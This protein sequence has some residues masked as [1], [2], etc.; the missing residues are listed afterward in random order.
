MQNIKTTKSLC[1]E[2]LRV[3]DAE[4]YEDNGK[5][6]I[7]KTCEIHGNFKDLYWS[8]YSLFEKA[9]KYEYIGDGIKNPRTSIDKGCPYDCGICPSHKS[10]T[11]LAIIDVTNRCNL[12]CPICF[13]NAAATGYVYEPTLEEIREMLKNLRS[14]QPIAPNSIQFSGGEPTVREDLP[15]LITMAKELGFHHVEVNTNGIRIAKDPEYLKK[16]LNAGLSTLY[17]Q[18]DGLTSEPY[19]AARGLDLLNI[20]LKVIE[21]ARKVGLDSIVL[22]PTIVKGINDNQ[23]GNI[24]R[25]AAKNSDVIRGVNFQPVSITGRINKEKLEE[26]RITIPDVIKLAE[27]QTNG[28]IKVSDFYPTPVVLPISKAVGA[29]KRRRYQEFTNHQHCGMATLIIPEGDRLVPITRYAN[30]EKFM[31][32]MK[33]V[34]DAASHGSSFKARMHLLSAIRHVKLSLIKDLILSV[35]I[36][37]DY[38]SLG[39]FMRKVILIGCMHFMDP[40]NFDLERVKRCTI[41]YAVPEGK[42]IPFCTMNSIHRPI[43]ERKYSK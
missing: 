11:V 9:N 13:A 28:E 25:F 6:Y 4:I 5:V 21:N 42:I 29:L 2:C 33:K 3:I 8:D 30:I 1:P 20:K 14:N 18:F 26:M 38:D 41:H 34:Y 7:R 27:E 16:L 24:I 19:L 23:I 15:E 22:V 36:Q 32:S 37:G 40:Y 10:H 35:L 12:K 31:D 43:L 39:K 17:L